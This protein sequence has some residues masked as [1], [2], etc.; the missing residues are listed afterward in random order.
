MLIDTGRAQVFQ[1]PNA[2]IF[3]QI[4]NRNAA[5]VAADPINGRAGS[6]S[7]SGRERHFR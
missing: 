4:Q 1:S 6:I 5:A 3:S 2:H 7:A